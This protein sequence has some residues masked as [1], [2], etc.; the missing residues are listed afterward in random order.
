MAKIELN[1]DNIYVKI[2]NT[3][4]SYRYVGTLLDVLY[5]NFNEHIV[6]FYIKNFGLYFK[7][8]NF[9]YLLNIQP[10]IN[11]I[12]ICFWKF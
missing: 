6:T 3:K 11:K 10:L 4:I 5:N 12:V 9:N 2:N 7:G 1:N 8:L